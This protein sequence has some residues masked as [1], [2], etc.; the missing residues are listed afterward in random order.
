ML[1]TSYTFNTVAAASANWQD[2]TKWTPSGFPNAID[3]VA[4]F[5][6]PATTAPGA[7][8]LT[9]SLA[10]IDTVGSIVVDNT[11]NPNNFVTRINGTGGQLI[12]QSSTGTATYT[13]NAGTP[14]TTNNGRFVI[15]QP[16]VSL[17]SNL[18]VTQD[19]QTGLNTS[20][21]FGTRVDG[22]SNI[23]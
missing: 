15:N 9:I 14:N 17:L 5:V 1:A 21:E 4:N 3:D 7:N 18:V 12:F 22:A 6:M 16:T 8:G 20:T 23:T 10:G 19:N 13:E 11:A 2:A